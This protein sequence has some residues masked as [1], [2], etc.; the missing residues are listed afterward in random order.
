MPR[1]TVPIL[2]WP[3]KAIVRSSSLWM[4]SSAASRPPRPSRPGRRGTRGRCRCRGRRAPPPSARPGP[5]RMP[6]SMC[7]SICAPTASTM[8]GS[9][10]MLD[11]APSSW[12]PPWLQTI[13]ASAPDATA[14]FA[15]STSWM[16]L[17]IS[18]PPQRFLIHSTSSQLSVR[19]ELLGGPVGQRTHVAHALDVADDVAELAP[20]GAQHAQAPARLGHHVDDVGERE[21]AAARTGRSSGPCGAG[22]GSAGRASAPA[23]EQ[24]AA[25]ARSIRRSMKSRSRIT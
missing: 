14:S 15:S 9:A 3:Q 17:R 19:V 21:L 20:A 7:T 4:I 6:P 5:E 1:S 2:V 13:S 16:P 23:R 25:L 18:L 11:C 10:S 8:A 12:R 22:R 24:L